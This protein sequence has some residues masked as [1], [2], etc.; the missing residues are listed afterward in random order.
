MAKTVFALSELGAR[1]KIIANHDIARGEIVNVNGIIGVAT[2]N[3]KTGK[4]AALLCEGIFLIE[5]SVP[6][7]VF[8]VGSSVYL[9]AGK[10]ALSGSV[11]MG[12]A[13]DESESGDDEVLVKLNFGNQTSASVQPQLRLT[14]GELIALMAANDGAGALEPGLEY[15]V[16]NYRTMNNYRNGNTVLP[17][18]NTAETEVLIVKAI[19]PNSISEDVKSEQFP[20]DI[21]FYDSGD[22]LCEDGVTAR[23]GY[24]YFRMNQKKNVSAFEDFRGVRNYRYEISGVPEYSDS[25]IVSYESL[26]LWNGF[27]YKASREVPVGAFPDFEPNYWVKWCD[28]SGTFTNFFDSNIL[29]GTAVC[30]T[31]TFINP[32]PFYLFSLENGEQGCEFVRNVNIQRSKTGVNSNNVFIV[33]SAGQITENISIGHDSTN[34]TL[35]KGVRH[36]YTQANFT[37]NL[38]WGGNSY[39]NSIAINFSNNTIGSGFYYNTTSASFMGNAIDDSC[40]YNNFAIEFVFNCVGPN[41]GNNKTGIDNHHMSFGTEVWACEIGYYN[42]GTKIGSFCNGLKT[43]S[44]FNNCIVPDSC[45]CV[46]PSNVTKDFTPHA[47]LL[48]GVPTVNIVRTPNEKVYITYYN[49]SLV[50]QSVEVV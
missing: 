31:A 22:V 40:W 5:K 26:R 49:N 1:I 34:N 36:L 27:I 25:E 39:E 32:Q 16:T 19:T 13:V 50:F 12:K 44:N 6:E 42:S 46:F 38:F 28:V 3:V 41:F 17:G 37:S 10:A 35:L 15:R 4:E 20:G 24:I 7:Q 8:E 9:I 45:G 2:N 11:Y 33:N 43:G 23:P 30:P 18:V 29:K 21:I 47:A 48:T 14:H